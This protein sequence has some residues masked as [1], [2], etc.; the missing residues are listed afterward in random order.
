[1]C[2]VFKRDGESGEESLFVRGDARKWIHRTCAGLTEKE[3][4]EIGADDGMW[5]CNRCSEV[6]AL[7][8]AIAGL[9]E[10][11][12]ALE[13]N[14]NNETNVHVLSQFEVR[15]AEVAVLQSTVASLT[16]MNEINV[17]AYSLLEAKV[18]VLE[19]ALCHVNGDDLSNVIAEC[20]V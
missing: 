20:A 18:E 19:V 2:G 14:V 3:F 10:K 11:V 6:S 1:M 9:T 4:L 12:C 7:Q 15:V 16:E 17:C 13:A 5:A 8:S